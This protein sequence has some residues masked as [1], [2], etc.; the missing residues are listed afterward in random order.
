M[1]V[2]AP[3][4]L[5]FLCYRFKTEERSQKVDDFSSLK[6]APDTVG[7]VYEMS[8]VMPHLGIPRSLVSISC[9]SAEFEVR[10]PS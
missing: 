9:V 3:A 2:I 4:L 1:V 10:R 5:T 8:V 7:P 6:L